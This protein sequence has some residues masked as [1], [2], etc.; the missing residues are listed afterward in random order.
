[1]LQCGIWRNL[2]IKDCMG[3]YN[4]HIG[5]VPLCMRSHR[6]LLCVA[7]CVYAP[8]HLN[9]RP[10]FTIAH[11]TNAIECKQL[12]GLLVFCGFNNPRIIV[13]C[14]SSTA[15][16]PPPRVCRTLR[17]WAKRTSGQ[18]WPTICHVM[19]GRSSYFHVVYP[20]RD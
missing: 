5:Q 14:L 11:N 15:P 19:P 18:F 17:V 8:I 3:P 13:D 12:H 6:W 16:P 4:D 7:I 9:L 10:I 1:M 20:R 2:F